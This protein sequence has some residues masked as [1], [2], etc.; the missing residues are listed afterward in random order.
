MFTGLRRIEQLIQSHSAGLAFITVH[1]D[2]LNQLLEAVKDMDENQRA[3]TSAAYGQMLPQ[4]ASVSTIGSSTGTKDKHPGAPPVV[5]KDAIT[6]R[7]GQ[8]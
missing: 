6:V 2:V 4:L 7:Y 5:H 8:L 3:G 1:N